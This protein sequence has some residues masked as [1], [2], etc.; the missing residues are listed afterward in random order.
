[1]PYQRP[2]EAGG[3]AILLIFHRNLWRLLLHQDS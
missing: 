1:M 2:L 3:G